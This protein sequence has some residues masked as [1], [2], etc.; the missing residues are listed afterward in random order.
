MEIGGSQKVGVRWSG[1]ESVGAVGRGFWGSDR[2][3]AHDA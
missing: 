2:G 1:L 3:K